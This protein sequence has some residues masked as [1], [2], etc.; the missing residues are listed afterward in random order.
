M[1]VSSPGGNDSGPGSGPEGLWPD[2]GQMSQQEL[3][4]LLQAHLDAPFGI[5]RRGGPRSPAA[6]VVMPDPPEQA[7]VM[8]VR[9]DLDGARPPV[10][11][12]LRVRGDVTMDRL[13]G[14]LQGAMGWWDCHLHRFWLGPEKQLWIG[15]YLLTDFDV[16]EGEEGVHERDVRLDQVVRSVGDRVF[17]TYDYGDEWNHTIWVE[18]FEPMSPDTPIA[19]CTGGRR[20]GPMEDIGGIHVH[21]DLVAAHRDGGDAT[22]EQ[23]AGRDWDPAEF[24]VDAVNG[25]ITLAIATPDEVMDLLDTHRGDPVHPGLADVFARAPR[26]LRDDLAATLH[27]DPDRPAESVREAVVG[28]FAILLDVAGQDGLPLTGAGWMQPAVVETLFRDLS[29]DT[30]WIGQGNRESQTQPVHLLRTTA[31]AMGLLRKRHNRLLATP[32]GRQARTDHALLWQRLVDWL[33]PD[34]PGAERDATVL[35][36]AEVA[37]DGEVDSDLFSRVATR[38]TQ[39]GW[40]VEGAPVPT[41]AAIDAAD[42]QCRMLNL[43]RNVIAVSSPDL[44]TQAIATLARTALTG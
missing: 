29:M 37:P 26:G 16:D 44:A 12:R 36:L 3:R 14:V 38:L 32:T 40:N 20:R 6:D 43:I 31:Q 34:E 8:V 23:V 7:Q 4:A 22:A 25:S 10:W 17:Y 35:L 28:P 9:V 11:R 19:V 24:D 5:D 15:P 13:H 41:R 42:P 1:A 27:S 33:I 30:F 2:L 21:N 18:A 39:L